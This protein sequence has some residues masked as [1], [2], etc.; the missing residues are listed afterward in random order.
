MTKSAKI[1][2]F[3]AAQ[4]DLITYMPEKKINEKKIIL[5]PVERTR[6]EFFRKSQKKPKKRTLSR[7]SAEGSNFVVMKNKN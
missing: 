2:I 7:R 1:L 6:H 3:W 5:R 4:L